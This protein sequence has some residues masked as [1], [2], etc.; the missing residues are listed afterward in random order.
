MTMDQEYRIWQWRWCDNCWQCLTLQP[1]RSVADEIA[2][3]LVD[4][5]GVPQEWIVV[6]A[7]HM[8]EPA[9]LTFEDIVKR[10]GQGYRI[11][12]TKSK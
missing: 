3:K 2:S 12:R 11:E 9:P 6:V 4:Q 10:K 8:P 7:D 5:L 1:S